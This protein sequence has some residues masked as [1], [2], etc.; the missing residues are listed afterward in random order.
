MPRVVIISAPS[1]AGKTTITRTL[2]EKHPDTY[3]LSVSA[4]TRKP[5]TGEK[6]GDAYHFLDR[7]E[8]DRWKRDGRFLETA[9]YAGQ[10]YGT[11]R[12]EVDRILGSGRHA[13]LDI[14]VV[15]AEQIRQAWPGDNLVSVFVLPSSPD[16]LVGRLKGRGTETADQI[17]A[18]LERAQHE[19]QHSGAFDHVVKNDELDQAVRTLR[20]I[21]EQ[22]RAPNMPQSAPWIEGFASGF[23]AAKLRLYSQ[24]KGKNEDANR[25]TH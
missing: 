2:V 20:D 3:A 4:T 21:V 5:R 16:V 24:L 25:H 1:G 7:A 9:E 8:F 10:W 22:G 19:L 13:L 15:G 6:D 17:R 11:P 12:S 14:E 18:R 23:Q